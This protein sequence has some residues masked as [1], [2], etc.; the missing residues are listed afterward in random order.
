M[1]LSGK[2]CQNRLI[3]IFCE[4]VQIWLFLGQ[5]WSHRSKFW[6]SY[7]K[8]FSLK[9]YKKYFS[10]VHGHEFGKK[11]MSIMDTIWSKYAFCGVLG[12][13]LY[14]L[15]KI[16]DLKKNHKTY[17]TSPGVIP[18][19]RFSLVRYFTSPTLIRVFIVQNHK[20]NSTWNNFHT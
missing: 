16:C 12:F 8:S 18:L 3:G 9:F 14:F 15:V 10:Q 13:P 6:E 17:L 11:K 1:S 7:E 2:F 20:I 4:I 5:K 19:V